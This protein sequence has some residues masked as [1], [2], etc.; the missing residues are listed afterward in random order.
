MNVFTC[1]NSIDKM[2]CLY[3]SLQLTRTLF[4]LV[5]RFT[6]YVYSTLTS[7]NITIFTEFL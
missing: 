5:I 6:I 2:R 7:Y 1:M 4:V 3:P